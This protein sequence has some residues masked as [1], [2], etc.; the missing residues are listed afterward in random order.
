MKNVE[1]VAATYTIREAAQMVGV[2]THVLRYWE[3]ELEVDIKRNEMGH[4]IYS[5][6]DIKIMRR[7]K[8][9][10]DKGILLKAIKKLVHEMYIKLETETKEDI[11]TINCNKKEQSD[12]E[13]NGREQISR[14]QIGREQNSREQN[15]REQN[16]KELRYKSKDS[17]EENYG[18]KISTEQSDKERTSRE[19]ANKEQAN[20]EQTDKEQSSREQ[21]KV[22]QAKVEQAKVEQAKV[23][24][25]DKEQQEELV[26]MDFKMAQFQCIM[27]KVVSNSIKENLRLISQTVSG[28]VS[29]NVIKQMDML[30]DER[31]TAQE[32]RYRKLDAA[33]RQTMEARM[34]VAAT[35]QQ[36]KR[37]GIF[38][39]KKV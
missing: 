15:N 9:L 10:K 30:L 2:E 37:R 5:D 29:E 33:I 21:A 7:V 27:D 19:Q 24:Q 13:Q 17:I 32:E 14:E 20:R 36:K 22:E 4:R 18:E 28:D 34:Q 31:E 11:D 12:K 3:D 35:E 39:K 1:A 38:R 16:N 6:I 23:E 26:I 8:T 25:A